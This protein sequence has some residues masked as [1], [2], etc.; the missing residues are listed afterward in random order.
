M[1]NDTCCQE[2]SFE[3]DVL[4]RAVLMFKRA[5]L[6]LAMRLRAGAT[7]YLAVYPM[8]F[9]ASGVRRVALSEGQ[10]CASMHGAQG[11][12][13]RRARSCRA[14]G[15]P[16]IMASLSNTIGGRRAGT[17]IVFLDVLEVAAA[18]VAAHFFR[19]TAWTTGDLLAI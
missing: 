12:A 5:A 14:D 6:G 1:G 8:L 16:G 11:G 15:Q 7:L 9:Y 10:P 17:S 13:R 19:C 18:P 4:S 2:L 3:R